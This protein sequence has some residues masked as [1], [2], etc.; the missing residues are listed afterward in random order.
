[1]SSALK[2]PVC[3]S[4]LREIDREGVSIDVCPQCRGVWLDRGE[5]EKLSGLMSGA[6]FAEPA[7]AMAKRDDDGYSR[8]TPRP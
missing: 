8:R 5:L 4:A 1:M 3:Q 2:C 7:R 6:G